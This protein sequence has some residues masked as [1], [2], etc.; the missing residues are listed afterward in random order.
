MEKKT[1]V[2]WPCEQH[3]DDKKHIQEQI[4]NKKCNDEK[5]EMT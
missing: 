2:I 1:T 5:D 4:R 3:D